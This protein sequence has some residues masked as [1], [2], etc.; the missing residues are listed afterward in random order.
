MS[1]AEHIDAVQATWR[2]TGG[3]DGAS[4]LRYLVVIDLK[5]LIRYGLGNSV[6]RCRCWS[7]PALASF[8]AVLNFS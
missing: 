8:C 7:F 1:G 5:D 6:D 4:A 3:L 2:A